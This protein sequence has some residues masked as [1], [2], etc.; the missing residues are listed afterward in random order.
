VGPRWA[1]RFFEL[2]EDSEIEFI[3]EPDG[4]V[5]GKRLVNSV[6]SRRPSDRT[7]RIL[8]TASA[9]ASHGGEAARARFPVDIRQVVARLTHH[10]RD[11]IEPDLVSPVGEQRE[12][13]GVERA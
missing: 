6:G 12:R 3:K 7:A 1:A 5:T 11:S 4:A 8:A 13:A 2:V 9:A 10:L